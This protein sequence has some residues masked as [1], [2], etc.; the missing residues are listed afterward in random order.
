VSWL[1]VILL[2]ALL[3]GAGPPYRVYLPLVAAPR[4]SCDAAYPTV[5]IP[6]PPPDLNCKDVPFRN[7]VVLPPDPHGFD[8]DHDGIGCEA[9]PV[10]WA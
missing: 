9:G 3:L 4:V 7:F 2:L 6:P 10:R 8:T 5:C 1:R